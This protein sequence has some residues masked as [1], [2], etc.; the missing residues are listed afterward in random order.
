[1]FTNSL[2]YPLDVFFG[3]HTNSWSFRLERGF[4]TAQSEVQGQGWPAAL[5]IL[6]RLTALVV[7]STCV[8]LPDGFRSWHGLARPMGWPVLLEEFAEP[9]WACA[10]AASSCLSDLFEGSLTGF[11]ALKD[12]TPARIFRALLLLLVMLTLP[13]R[14]IMILRY[15]ISIPFSGPIEEDLAFVQRIKDVSQE[16]EAW[17]NEQE[18]EHRDK[19][20]CELVF[21]DRSRDEGQGYV[22]LKFSDAS[23]STSESSASEKMK[24]GVRRCCSQYTS[25]V[26]L[27][28][29]RPSSTPLSEQYT[30]CCPQ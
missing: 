25:S 18:E 4:Q 16:I 13:L 14:F 19:S 28:E 5:F 27:S 29:D 15:L 23:D 7:L 24:L 8:D 26:P 1:M 6:L 9:L 12:Q 17:A 2:L 20:C 30:F 21:L 11:G 22:C 3:Y 10:L